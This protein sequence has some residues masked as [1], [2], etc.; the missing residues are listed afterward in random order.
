MLNPSVRK[1]IWTYT[2]GNDVQQNCYKDFFTAQMIPN[3]M[4]GLGACGDLTHSCRVGQSYLWKSLDRYR[5]MKC[6]VHI[7]YTDLFPLAKILFDLSR[8]FLYNLAT[9]GTT[10]CATLDLFR[11]DPLT[12]LVR[13]TEGKML[14]FIPI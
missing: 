4:N 9:S 11:T 12:Q 14:F 6:L 5:D 8:V 2:L 3:R 7:F 13:G 10:L 1:I